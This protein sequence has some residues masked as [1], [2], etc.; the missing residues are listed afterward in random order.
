MLNYIALSMR[1][2]LKCHYGVAHTHTSWYNGVALMNKITG[3]G[4]YNTHWPWIVDLQS[5]KTA[6]VFCQY[7]N[8]REVL[9]LTSVLQYITL[10]INSVSA[11][12][13]K[14]ENLWCIA[15]PHD[16]PFSE[17]ERRKKNDNKKDT[18]FWILLDVRSVIRSTKQNILPESIA[19]KWNL[20]IQCTF[21]A[22]NSSGHVN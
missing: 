9:N 20:G 14:R 18:G 16:T 3:F 8:T 13:W 12:M 6:T 17:N 22:C 1:I 19:P 10:T 21:P 5:Y 15:G 4:I 11:F 2:V 7:S